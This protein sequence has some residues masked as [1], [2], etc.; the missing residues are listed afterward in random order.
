MTRLLPLLLLLFG[1]APSLPVSENALAPDEVQ[2]SIEEWAALVAEGDAA[3]DVYFNLGHAF[4]AN[5]DL[6]SAAGYWRVSHELAPRSGDISHNLAMV[7]TELDAADE[8]V[9]P[10]VPWGEL[11]TPNELG[12]LGLTLVV[13]G[14]FLIRARRRRLALGFLLVGLL[15]G[16][17][18]AQARSSHGQQPIGV[19]LRDGLQ[20]RELPRLNSPLLGPVGL[21][22]ELRVLGV[23]GPFALVLDGRERRGWVPLEELRIPTRR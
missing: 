4:Y 19:C 23:A 13:L 17:Q 7:R 5:G 3:V 8:P 10:L 18:A 16:L 6:A 1:C 14:L 9:P 2:A 11:L 12:A 22:S 15:V 21:G 20:L